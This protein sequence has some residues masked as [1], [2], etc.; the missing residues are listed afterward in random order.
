MRRLFLVLVALVLTGAPALHAQPACTRGEACPT[1][2]RGVWL[3]N[4]DSDVLTTRAKIAEAMDHLASRGFN[5]VFPVVYNGGYTLH[6]SDVMAATFGESRRVHPAFGGRDVLDELI[7]EGHRAGLEVIPWFEY[8]FA[9]SYGADGGH[10]LASKPAWAA[11]GAN[12]QRVVKNGFYWLDALNPE[13]QDWM[14][15]LVAE[16]AARYD[17]DGIQGDDRLP[18]MAAEGGYSAV[19]RQQYAADFGGA[20]LPAFASE[21]GFMRWK[22]G[23]LTTWLGHL[24]RRIKAIDPNLTVSMSPSPYSFGYD[25]YLQDSP[26]W[27]DSAYVDAFHPQLYRYDLAAYRFE[28][29]KALNALPNRARDLPK[30]APG[31]LLKAGSQLN[32]PTYAVEAVRYNRSLGING[33]VFFFYEGLRSRNQYVSDSLRKYVYP[34]PALMPGRTGRWRPPAP[35][36]DELAATAGQSAWQTACIVPGACPA[37]GYGGTTL[38]VATAAS[39]A[40]AVYRLAVPAAGTYD[41]YAWT[42]AFSRNR[43]NATTAA[44][45]V[46]RTRTRTGDLPLDSTVV[47]V[48]QASTT[49]PA[50]WRRIGRLAV[51]D[52][53]DAEVVVDAGGAADGRDT[54]TDAVMLV[55]NRR[56]SPATVVTPTSASAA[57][58]PPADLFRIEAHPSVVRAGDRVTLRLDLPITA[59]AQINVYD[60]AGRTVSHRASP[61]LTASHGIDLSTDGLAPGLYLVEVRAGDA[62]GHARIVV[63]G[64]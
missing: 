15:A 63:T 28:A 16:V 51:A 60:A 10:I 36:V 2:L 48:D 46:L 14:S 31:I 30:L 17:V 38:R 47:T 34:T 44:R 45:V 39:R 29:Q 24:Y 35:L 33:E 8:G 62:V 57:P 58:R 52:G 13:V 55:L 54:H 4:V 50:G 19:N 18:A 7:V 20:A 23:K 9:A 49:L 41:V 53:A 59:D 43:P 64:R 21:A 1:E 6:P 12:G 26:R 40:R 56:L 27:L 32:G 37:D 22:A 25:E 61:R 42:P 5:V 3:T 11:I